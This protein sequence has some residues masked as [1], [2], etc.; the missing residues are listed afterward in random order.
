M[1]VWWLSHDTRR[2]GR[3]WTVR[4]VSSR[5]ATT[6]LADF[7]LQRTVELAEI[8]APTSHEG[9]RARRVE[10]WWN[11]DNRAE[12]TIDSVGNVWAQVR[13]GDGPA[14]LVCA[15]L[16]TVFDSDTDHRVRRENGRL[17]GP[18]VGDDSIG[19]AALSALATLLD[20]AVGDRP[21][22]IAATVGEEGLGNLVGIIHAVA[23]P[24][25]PLS[26]V[27]AV[28]GNYLGKVATVGVGSIRWHVEIRGPGGHA[29]AESASPS[30]V[31]EAASAVHRLGALPVDHGRISVNVGRIGG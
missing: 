5:R 6:E 3:C 30:A 22:W 17:V 26:G 15:H 14:L 9:P 20:D 29:W 18:G 31:H 21:V 27:I 8:P 16:D 11:T 23:H 19:L 25:Q 10:E 7:V 24:P 13:E 2:D 12:V 28:E 4:T 1:T